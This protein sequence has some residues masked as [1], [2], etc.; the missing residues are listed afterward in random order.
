MP[1]YFVE[2]MA[3]IGYM[4]LGCAGRIWGSDPFFFRGGGEYLES[5]S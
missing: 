3:E 4:V 1:F 5:E 2:S